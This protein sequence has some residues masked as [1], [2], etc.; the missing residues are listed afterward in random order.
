VSDTF[1][2]ITIYEQ[3]AVDPAVLRAKLIGA[4]IDVKPDP[5]EC[6]GMP[7]VVESVVIIENADDSRTFLQR[8]M[9]DG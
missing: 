8:R 2:I 9:A 1:A 5:C 7:V 3:D 4:G 6:C